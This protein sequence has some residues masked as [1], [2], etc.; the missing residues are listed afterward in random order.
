M[1]SASVELF[2]SF[3]SLAKNLCG[4]YVLRGPFSCHF[5]A[6]SRLAAEDPFRPGRE[7]STL[8]GG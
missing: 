4:S 1:P 7:H 2:R 3:L 6:R 5:R 8:G